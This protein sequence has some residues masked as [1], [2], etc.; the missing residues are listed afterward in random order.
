VG[1]GYWVCRRHSYKKDRYINKFQCPNN[2]KENTF[3]LGDGSKTIKGCWDSIHVV[4]V[5]VHQNAFHRGLH[6]LTAFGGDQ[7]QYQS[8]CNA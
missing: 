1:F 8:N 6:G 5:Q 7:S 2:Y 3:L 4:E